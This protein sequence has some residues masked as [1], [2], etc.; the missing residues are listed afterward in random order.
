MVHRVQHL[1]LGCRVDRTD[2]HSNHYEPDLSLIF[3]VVFTLIKDGFNGS[4]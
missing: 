4:N 3:F 2:K 1:F